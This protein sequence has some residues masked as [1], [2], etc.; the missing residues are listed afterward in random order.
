MK[1]AIKL[2]QL[3]ISSSFKSA[4]ENL[5]FLTPGDFAAISRQARFRPIKNIKDMIARLE[6]EISVKK[7]DS[8]RKMGFVV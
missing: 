3:I 1:K 2:K 5:D 4:I 8:S 6:D 7:V